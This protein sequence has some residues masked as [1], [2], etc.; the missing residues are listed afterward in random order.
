MTV[1]PKSFSTRRI[2]SKPTQD[3]Q[4]DDSANSNKKLP[5]PSFQKG[6]DVSTPKCRKFSISQ[7]DSSSSEIL[8]VN[9]GY[10]KNL[11]VEREELVC[12]QF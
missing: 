4:T 3:C 7:P 6:K 1:R 8:F 5:F 9:H 12:I 11:L 2:P 10:S